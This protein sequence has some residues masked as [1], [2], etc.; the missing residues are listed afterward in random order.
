[1]LLAE[2]MQELAQLM[3]DIQ[4]QYGDSVADDGHLW[5]EGQ[6]AVAQFTDDSHFYRARVLNVIDADTVEVTLPDLTLPYLRGKA[7]YGLAMRRRQ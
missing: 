5:V 1:M 2:D 7:C 4:K 3:V 6:I